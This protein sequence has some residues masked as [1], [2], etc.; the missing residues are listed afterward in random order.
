LSCPE[1]TASSASALQVRALIEQFGLEPHPEGGSFR[2]IYRASDRV[3]TARSVRSAITAVHYLLERTQAS[4]WHIVQSDDIW[5]FYQGSPLVLLAYDPE[6]RALVRYVLGNTTHDHQR[7]GD[8]QWGLA[9]CPQ[10]R[11]L[12]TRRLQRWPRFRVRGFQL[13]RQLSAAPDAF[14][15]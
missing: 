10:P 8:P 11:R 1:I 5:H 4:R 6:K 13:C 7:V 15:R 12:L 2:E 14:R 3:Q 9:G